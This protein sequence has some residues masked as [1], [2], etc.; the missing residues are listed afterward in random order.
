[1]K[2]VY[3]LPVLIFFTII[4]AFA[5]SGFMPIYQPNLPSSGSPIEKYCTLNEFLNS[6]NATTRAFTCAAGGSGGG[7]NNTASNLGT[8]LGWY[9]Q[10]VGV[11]LQFNSAIAGDGIDITDT[12]NDLTIATDFKIDTLPLL[13]LDQF[14]SSFDNATGDW[15]AKIFSI[16]SVDCGTDFVQEIDNSTGQV[17]CAT[18]G[19]GESNTMSSPTHAN[20]L[21]L[22]KSGVDLPIKGIACG[23]NTS[24]SA[25]STDITISAT[26]GGVSDGDKG[27]ITVTA[28]G[29]TW[30]IDPTVVTY[31]KIQNVAADDRFLGRISGAGGSIE[32]LTGTQATTLLDVFTSAL[33]GLVPAS[34]GGTTNFLRA[35]GT[36]AAPS[37]GSTPRGGYLMG[38]WT[39][40]STKTNIGTGFVDVYTQTNSNGKAVFIDTDTF[41]QVR[42]QIQ[43]NKVGAGTQT[44]QVIN[45]ATVLVSMNVVSGSND[46]GFVAIPAGLL[47]AE[48]SFRLQCKSTT[49]ADDPI[50]ESAAIWLK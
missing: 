3:F 1:M 45:G 36:W 14:I 18:G 13:S 40:S 26:G 22:T 32:E 33:K 41:T 2:L 10:K 49:A 20:S 12:T 17:I 6:Y 37:G 8:G 15:T 7:E 31:A 29:A 46:S 43:W 9:K 4:P 38:M 11:D 23:T 5:N 42:L 28:S 27:D 50:F 19:G 47:N 39:Q 16:N 34:G 48:N 30:T 24:C 44:C 35:D 21:V 25:N